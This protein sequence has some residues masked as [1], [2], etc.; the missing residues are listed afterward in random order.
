LFQEE[1]KT[2]GTRR[3]RGQEKKGGRDGRNKKKQKLSPLKTGRETTF[4]QRVKGPPVEGEK[5]IAER[6]SNSPKSVRKMWNKVETS[7][8]S[9]K[10]RTGVYSE[11]KDYASQPIRVTRRLKQQTNQ[12]D[13]ARIG[14]TRK[15]ERQR[16]AANQKG[17]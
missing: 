8:T 12:G 3:E 2:Q 13:H 9:H 4:R 10:K 11:R 6:N 15:K 14:M 7:P 16:S 5:K 1:L 17:S